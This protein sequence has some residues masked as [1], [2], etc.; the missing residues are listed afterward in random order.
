M[1][2][3]DSRQQ[4]IPP[5]RSCV[6]AGFVVYT[7]DSD[8][9]SIVILDDGELVARELDS[10]K[11]ISLLTPKDIVFTMSPGDLVGVAALL[12]GEPFKYE[13]V[14]TKDS[15]ITQ[16][17]EEC[18]ESELKR[19][20]VWL[21]AVIRSIS[22][23]TRLLKQSTHQTQVQNT[24]KSLAMFLSHK[25]GKKYLHLAEQLQEFHWLTKIPMSTILLDV[26][27]LSR[28]HL[29]EL[30]K[31]EGIVICTIPNPFLLKI[32]VDYQA[33]EEEHRDFAPYKL[34][35]YQ[36]KVLALLATMDSS[37][38]QESPY[39]LD[40]IKRNDPKAD[41]TEWILLQKLGWFTQVEKNLFSIDTDKVKY[42]LT[43]L[44][45]ETNI[46]GVL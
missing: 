24:V 30:S 1:K 44:R 35:L 18:M 40:F 33:C 17:N 7:P 21:L 16:V 13:L 20:P 39:W 10:P 4:T 6:K 45:Y 8:E 36:K 27:G 22:N 28:R 25:P 37:I 26:K 29:V 32:F 31:K 46:R 11:D 14:A 9:R 23:K 41:V 5:A 19:L 34:T 43:A 12:E 38:R 42:F 3:A 2:P 15:S